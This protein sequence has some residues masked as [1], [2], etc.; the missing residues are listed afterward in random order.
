[1]FIVQLIN[2]KPSNRNTLLN[3]PVKKCLM[4]FRTDSMMSDVHDYVRQN[5]PGFTDPLTRPYVM[6][7]GGLGPITSKSII[8]R[9]NEFSLFLSTRYI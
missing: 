6:N 3:I 2:L 5:L 7:H 8:D 9:K 1:M 4:L